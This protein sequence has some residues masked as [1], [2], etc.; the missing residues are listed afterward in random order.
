MKNRVG[1]LK[2]AGIVVSVFIDADLKQVAKLGGEV[3]RQKTEIPGMGWYGIFK[4]PTGNVLAI[5][6][7]ENP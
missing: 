5:Y 2:D 1:K 6:T 7:S 4:D 3:L